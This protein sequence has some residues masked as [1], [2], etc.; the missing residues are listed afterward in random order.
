MVDSLAQTRLSSAGS[1]ASA[2]WSS[3]KD[4]LSQEFGWSTGHLSALVNGCVFAPTLLTFWFANG[5]ADFSTAI[6]LGTVASPA[7]LQIR[8]LAYLL[9]VPVFIATRA[10]YYLLHPVHRQAVLSGS[11]PQSRLLSLDW[12]T[13]GILITGLPLALRDLGLWI[14]MNLV[15]LVGIFL[16]PRLVAD[17]RRSVAVK[18][19]AI[20][21]GV[22][23]FGYV[24]FGATAAAVVG[25][26]PQPAT[27]VGPVATLSMSEQTLDFLLRAM[28]SLLVGP[29]L[30]ALVGYVLNR[31]MTH[32]EV[33]N[34]PLLHYTIPRRDPWKVVAVSASL[35][36]VFYL[37]FLAALT[38]RLVLVP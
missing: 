8:L 23:L 37:L 34:I 24:K 21:L 10:G 32:P 17:G 15:F 28:N 2:L 33:T 25:L 19:G 20:I 30:V 14:S 35:G 3:F 22:G 13:V 29:P 31:I 38:G 16:L 36:T 11:C 27:V 12:F 4:L 26:V 6:L 9:V 5:V 1:T 7:G 18:V